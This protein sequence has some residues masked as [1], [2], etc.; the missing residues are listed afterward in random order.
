MTRTLFLLGLL[1]LLAGCQDKPKASAPPEVAVPVLTQ[2]VR[3]VS[4]NQAVPVS[5]ALEAD[6]TVGLGFQLGGQ[7]QQVYVEE[8]AA[9]RKGQLL[10]TLNASSYQYALAAATATLARAQDQYGRFKIMFGAASRPVT[11]TRPRR[12]TAR[13]RPGNTWPA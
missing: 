12:P 10:A 13:R 7:V 9:V 1:P 2:P 5:G 4:Q 3:S 6:Q 11:S 8:G